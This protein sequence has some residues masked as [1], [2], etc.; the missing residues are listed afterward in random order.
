MKLRLT[1]EQWRNFGQPD[2]G[3][4]IYLKDKKTKKRINYVVIES[5]FICPKKDPRIKLKLKTTTKNTKQ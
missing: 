4:K 1:A 3:S 5:D 2:I